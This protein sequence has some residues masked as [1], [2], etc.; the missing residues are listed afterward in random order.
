MHDGNS[1]VR[2]PVEQRRFP[3]IRPTDDGDVHRTDISEE[4]TMHE[5]S[6]PDW[7]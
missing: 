2:D 7:R 1:T 3:D 5:W 6:A 4:M